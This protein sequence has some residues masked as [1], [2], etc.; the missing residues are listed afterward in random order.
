MGI[1]A[2]EGHL[3]KVQDAW[4]KA[5]ATVRVMAGSYVAPLI[6]MLRAMVEHEKAKAARLERMR[7]RIYEEMDR[8]GVP[9]E[10][11]TFVRSLI[12]GREGANHGG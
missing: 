6:D 2:M 1:N 5:P 7:E 3:S 10:L 8:Q 11:E 9:D 4:D 12:D